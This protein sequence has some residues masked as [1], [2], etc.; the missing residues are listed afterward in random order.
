MQ[1]PDLNRILAKLFFNAPVRIRF[2]RKL[3]ALTRHGVI[4]AESVAE[5]Q[6]RY[7]KQRSPLSL[8]LAEISSRLDGGSKLHQAMQGFI[9]AEEVMLIDSGI[10]SGKLYESLDLAVQLI[11]ARMKIIGS[12]RK[13][14]AYPALLI[15]ALITLLIVF[16]RYAMPNYIQI[17]NPENWSDGAKLLY[18]VSCFID[19]TAGTILFAVIIL[20][21]LLSL[22]TIKIWTGNIRVRFDSI[23]P[24][25]FYRLIIGSL[26]LF[27]LAIL[28]KSGI[29]LST[30]IEKMLAI[31]DTGPWLRERLQSVLAQLT[32]GKKLGPALDDSGYQFPTKEIIEDLR[33]YSRLSNFHSQLYLIA[34]E[35]LAEGVEKV[36]TQAKIINYGCIITIAYLVSNIVLAMSDIQQQSGL[37]MAY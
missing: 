11:Q 13:A 18:R 8:V 30:A 12:M 5:L 17:S 20:S 35:M 26:W 33:I 23:P 14:L 15:S 25:S 32:K 34:E 29:Q 3:A 31:P 16:S 24:W 7:A 19:S 10:T 36:Q 6:E 37:N 22:A 21:G 9:P 2:Y 4:V 1:R 27:T 28:M